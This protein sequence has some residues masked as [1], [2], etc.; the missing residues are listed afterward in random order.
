MDTVLIWVGI[1]LCLSQSAM[2]SG[3]NLALFSVGRLRLEAEVEHGNKGA[4]RILKLRRD[5]NFLLCTILWGNVSVNVGLAL[6]MNSALAGIAGFLVSTFGITLIGEIVPQAYFSRNALRVGALFSPVIR[7]YKILLFPVAKP[8]ALLLDGWIGK[9]GPSFYRERDIETIL[10]KHIREQDSEIGATEGRGA[11]N[12]LDLDD[13]LI[14]EEGS[15]VVPET[16]YSF[17]TNMDLPVIPELGSP[18]GEAFLKALKTHHDKWAI[19]TDENDEPR[20]VLETEPY[21]YSHYATDEEVNPYDYCHRPVVIKEPNATLDSVLDQFVV[22]AEHREDV[23][24]DRDVII[25]WGE[26]GKRIVTGADI[27][28]RLL[29]GIAKRE[30]DPS[31]GTEVPVDVLDEIEDEE[32]GVEQEVEV[33]QHSRKHSHSSAPAP[34]GPIV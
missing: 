19:I 25:Y 4:A 27:L 30:R 3:L 7:F 21:L 17:S 31:V 20:I 24:I 18:E 8:S 33:K 12:F 9:E 34:T 14:A 2:F 5:A 32:I 23:I 11:L 28:G 26:G 6:L 29:R 15:A 22:E 1:A 13:R 10:E 16:I